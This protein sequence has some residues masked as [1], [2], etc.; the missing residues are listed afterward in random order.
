MTSEICWPPKGT[1]SPTA[2]RWKGDGY[3]CEKCW[4]S[5]HCPQCSD[6]C[7]GQGHYV[8]DDDG[9][10]FGCQEPER[11]ERQLSDWRRRAKLREHDAYKLGPLPMTLERRAAVA[12]AIAAK[13]ENDR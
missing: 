8:I 11:R 13:R 3:A 2:H 5:M 1:P 6:A 10:Y 4:A 12:A 9:G 7:G